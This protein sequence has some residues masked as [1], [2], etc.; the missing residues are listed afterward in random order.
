MKNQA[1]FMSRKKTKGFTLI[2]VLIVLAI[3]A[4]ILFAV[5]IAVGKVQTKQVSKEAAEMLNLMVADVRAK[6]KSQGNFTGITPQVLIDN[7]IPPNTMIEG[8]NI[9]SPWNSH[10]LVAPVTI[11]NPNDAVRF[12]YQTV[13]QEDCSNF[14]TAAQGTFT[15]ITVNGTV[16]KNVPTVPMLNV[17]QLGTACVAANT[18]TI[19]YD[20]VR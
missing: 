3:A 1:L 16:L 17:A 13:P 9:V 7:R 11:N 18:A 12:T 10:I 20:Q 2:E 14:V 19:F 4:G 8:A 6:F 15:R 5:F